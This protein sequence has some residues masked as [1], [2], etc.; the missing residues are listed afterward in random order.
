MVIDD[1]PRGGSLGWRRPTGV[2]CQGPELRAQIVSIECSRVYGCNWVVA[3]LGRCGDS[4]TML[5]LH[6][7]RCAASGGPQISGVASAGLLIGSTG[8]RSVVARPGYLTGRCDRTSVQSCRVCVGRSRYRRLSFGLDVWP[9]CFRQS[10]EKR[11]SEARP[12]GSPQVPTAPRCRFLL[13]THLFLQRSH[14]RRSDIDWFVILR[15][16]QAGQHVAGLGVERAAEPTCEFGRQ[17]SVEWIAT[18]IELAGN[19]LGISSGPGPNL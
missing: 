3:V 12:V 17:V 10:P 7:T 11:V 5:C 9:D 8:A 19:S 1:G 15:L 16:A 6:P 4:R 18:S 13:R 2:I 14:E